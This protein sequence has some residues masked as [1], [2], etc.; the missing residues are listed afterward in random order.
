MRIYGRCDKRLAKAAWARERGDTAS[1]GG[2]KDGW[3]EREVCQRAAAR[4]REKK[5]ERENPQCKSLK[6]NLG[7]DGLGL[8]SWQLADGELAGHG[9]CEAHAAGIYLTVDGC[10]RKMAQLGQISH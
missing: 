1:G 3:G 2:R 7:R 4:M 5:V 10:A 8:G 6:C 9:P